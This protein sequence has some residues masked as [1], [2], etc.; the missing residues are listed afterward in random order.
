MFRS[1]I[2]AGK[3]DAHGPRPLIIG[4]K[5]TDKD[6]KYSSVIVDKMMVWDYVLSESAVMSLMTLY[7]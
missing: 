5:F 3:G 1:F 7:L 4:R 2:I 6:D